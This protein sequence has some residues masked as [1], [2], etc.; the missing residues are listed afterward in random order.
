M[1]AYQVARRAS[2]NR[3][4]KLMGGGGVMQ[5]TC[6]WWDVI[7]MSISFFFMLR[8]EKKNCEFLHRPAFDP[9]VSGGSGS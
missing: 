6:R 9:V 8:T 2:E 7:F 5:N 4:K 1:S 3:G